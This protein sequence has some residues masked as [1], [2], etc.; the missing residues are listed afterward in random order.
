MFENEF[1]FRKNDFEVYQNTL[2]IVSSLN[3]EKG[4]VPTLMEL[5]HFLVGCKL[6]VVDGNSTDLT[7]ENAS[8]LGASV[9]FQKGKGKGDAIRYA[10]KYVENIFDYVVLIDADHTYPA[11][12]L[13]AMIH[14]LE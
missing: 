3:E 11:K 13:P 4:I 9:I 7:V 1:L 14:I 5:D 12:F 10:L 2:V 6:L 8:V